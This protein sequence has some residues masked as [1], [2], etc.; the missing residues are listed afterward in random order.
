MDDRLLGA[1]Q[2]FEG[3]LDQFL[4]RL[5]QHLD[6][7]VVG[8][9]VI[10]DQG[11]A[12]IVVNLTGGRETHLDFLIAELHQQL[13]KALLLSHVHRLDQRLVAVAQVHRRP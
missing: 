9:Q 13:E 6:A 2:R 4:A 8:H 1:L 3:A 5:G 11:P 10:L 7:D 12:E